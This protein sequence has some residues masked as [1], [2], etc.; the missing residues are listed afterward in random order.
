MKVEQ[1]LQEMLRENTGR[2][3]LDSGDIYGRHWER[4]QKVDDFE[5]Q[6]QGW[7]EVDVFEGRVYFN[8]TVNIYHFLK[9]HIDCYLE[10]L[11]KEFESFAD[12][13]P[14]KS[15]FELSHLFFESRC[16]ERNYNFYNT[17]N[18]EEC[19]S[20]VFEIHW[21]DPK[22]FEEFLPAKCVYGD[23]VAALFIHNGCDVRGGYTKPR[24][25]IVNGGIFGVANFSLVCPKCGTI[26]YG[27]VGTR[28]LEIVDYGYIEI[29]DLVPV[30]NPP[31]TDPKV[32]Q[33]KYPWYTTRG[34]TLKIPIIIRDK[35]ALCPYCYENY[36]EAAP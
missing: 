14:N 22:Y 4:N 21:C 10:E 35:K 33:H 28:E 6:P 30:L 3:L 13:Y 31:E 25:F 29:K 24:F 36:L 16:G 7:L 26:A 17:Y 8:P 34:G 19:L 12:E 27:T 2:A 18:G 5:K 20:Q 32:L 9:M 1:V 23:Y 11:Q 15:W